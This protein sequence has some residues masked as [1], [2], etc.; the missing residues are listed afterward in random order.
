MLIQVNISKSL[1]P[2]EKDFKLHVLEMF[3]EE[4]KE[5]ERDMFNAQQGEEF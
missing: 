4:L 1:S 5:S 2:K 3:L